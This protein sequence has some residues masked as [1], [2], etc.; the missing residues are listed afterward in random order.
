M[1]VLHTDLLV[2]GLGSA[3]SAAVYRA[4]QNGISVIGAEQMPG[5][6]GTSTYGGVN[7]WEPGVSYPGIHQEIAD[8]KSVV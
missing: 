3:G 5:P 7:N 8:R 1:R 4:L 2:I 6:G